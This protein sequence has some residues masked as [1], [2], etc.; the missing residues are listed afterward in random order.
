[1][2]VTNPSK[3]SSFDAD[4]ACS[5]ARRTVSGPLYSFCEYDSEAFRPLYVDDRTVAMY[6]GQA[7]M[8]EHFED[9]HN[10]VHMDFM[11]IELF[12]N[13]LFPP[14]E[15]VSYITTAMDFLKIVRMYVDDEGLFIAVAP[16][17]P[18]EP[19]VEAVE[20]AIGLAGDRRRLGRE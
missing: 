13:T 5:A 1:M 16:E 18:V 10:H 15:R 9:I 7:E 2:P 17:E 11:Q 20:D 12:R 3:H 6:D 4:A 19:L 8:A 14:A